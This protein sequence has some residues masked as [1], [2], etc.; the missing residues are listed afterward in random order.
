LLKC[1]IARVAESAGRRPGS[2]CR[3]LNRLLRKANWR[4]HLPGIAGETARSRPGRHARHVVDGVH[5]QQR[6][7]GCDSLTC[8]TLRRL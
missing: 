8:R 4:S 1:T 6:R 2:R 3:K 7:L 5:L